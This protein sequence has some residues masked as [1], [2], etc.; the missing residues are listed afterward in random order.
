M[1][2]HEMRWLLQK[3]FDMV[4]TVL[5]SDDWLRQELEA[6]VS[7]RMLQHGSHIDSLPIESSI[8]PID[9]KKMVQC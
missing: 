2:Q 8:S 3:N 4:V 7:C 1:D 6:K 9:S 5:A